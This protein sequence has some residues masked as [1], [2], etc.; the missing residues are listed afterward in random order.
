LSTKLK[1]IERLTLRLSRLRKQTDTT[2][3]TLRS[4]WCRSKA[5]PFNQ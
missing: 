5:L 2:E 4:N 3:L 1:Q